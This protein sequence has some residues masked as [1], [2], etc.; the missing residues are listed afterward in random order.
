M[1]LRIGID[2]VDV[3][4]VQEAVERHA[5]RY[6]DRV[7]TEREQRDCA[8]P[9]GPDPQRLASRFA[10]KEATLKVLRPTKT[11]VPWNSIE[12]VRGTDGAPTLAL[13]DAAAELAA[14]SELVEFAVSL[15][16]EGGLAAAVVAAEAPAACR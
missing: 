11:A 14:A 7:Y 15:T 12:V 4:A 6:L 13:R 1:P 5:A 3:D 8:R 16:H 9:G 10:A 2:L